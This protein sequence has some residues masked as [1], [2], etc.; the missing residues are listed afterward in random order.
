MPTRGL[1]L[2]DPAAQQVGSPYVALFEIGE[3]RVV[4]FDKDLARKNIRSSGPLSEEQIAGAMA[5]YINRDH[6]QLEQRHQEFLRQHRKSGTMVR[7]QPTDDP[8]R[9]RI[10]H[11]YSCQRHLD[12]NADW[13]CSACGWMLCSCG[14]CGCGYR[15][16][17]ESS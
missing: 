6:I 7:A 8:G 4:R 13:E 15:G 3:C 10:T 9:R 17:G 11:C 2:Y 12:S 16:Q 5:R 14:A 1:F